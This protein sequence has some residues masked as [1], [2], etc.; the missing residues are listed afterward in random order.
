MTPEEQIDLLFKRLGIGYSILSDLDPQGALRTVTLTIIKAA[1][2]AEREAIHKELKTEAMNCNP[3]LAMGLQRAADIIRV[4]NK[5]E[6][7]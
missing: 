4:R 3:G 2:E 7:T 5:Q 6:T 1:V